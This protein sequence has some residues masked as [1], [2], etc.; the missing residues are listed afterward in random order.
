[1]CFVVA[2]FFNNIYEAFKD[3]EV[4]Y[5]GETFL[6]GTFGFYFYVFCELIIAAVFIWLATGGIKEK[7]DGGVDEDKS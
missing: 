4:A 5:K 6:S 3:G 1:M 2:I 7:V